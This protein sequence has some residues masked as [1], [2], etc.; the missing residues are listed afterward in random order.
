[1]RFDP[2][3]EAND[4]SLAQ[5]LASLGDLFVNDAFADCHR[6]HAS[7]VGIARLLPSY[8]G[9]LLERE[10]T[11]LSKALTPPKPSLAIV[12]GAKLETKLPLIQKLSAIYDHVLVGGA[13]ANELKEHAPNVFVPEDGIPQFEGMFDIGPKAKDAW[14][15]EVKSARFVLWNGPVGWYEKGYGEA[16]YA[17]AQALADSG[18]EAVIGGGDTAAALAAYHFD[19]EKVFISTGGGATLEFLVGGT[20][21][22]IE[23]L[24]QH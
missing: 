23:A 2:R 24:R 12:G 1:V 4:S 10:I 3:E 20:L 11:Q 14:V 9:L 7:I 22:G 16:T 8:A 17:L 18:V 6:A 15:Q 5:E 21:P 13:L 19:P